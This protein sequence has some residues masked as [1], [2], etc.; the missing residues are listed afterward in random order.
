M[1]FPMCHAAGFSIPLSHARGGTV[2]LMRSFDVEPF[3][4]LVE[5]HR[6]ER[7]SLAPTMAAFVL[8]HPALGRFDTSSLRGSATAE[9]RCRWRQPEDWRNGSVT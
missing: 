1:T 3:L 6:I 5:E 2:V 4:S 8:A 9:C 7:S